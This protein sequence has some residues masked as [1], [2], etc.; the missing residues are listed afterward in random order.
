MLVGGEEWGQLR[1]EHRLAE[2]CCRRRDGLI[3]LAPQQS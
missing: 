1:G 2:M 3:P